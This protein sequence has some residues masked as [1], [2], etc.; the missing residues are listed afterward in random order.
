MF[1]NFLESRGLYLIDTVLN[2]RC[3]KGVREYLISWEGYG[4]EG[5][6]WEPEADICN[7][8][9]IQEYMK[10]SYMSHFHKIASL[11]RRKVLI[12]IFHMV[13]ISKND[14]SN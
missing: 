14:C 13:V 9:L 1:R 5:N 10:F 7:N 3:K 8:P 6:Y 2:H 4:A 11:T 12:G